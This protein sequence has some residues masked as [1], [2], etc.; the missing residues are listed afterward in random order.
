MKVAVVT[1]SAKGLGRDIAMVL[2]KDGY[3]VVLHYLH[4]ADDAKKALDEIKEVSP[5]SI[6]VK[7]N[8]TSDSDT[9]K[10][11]GEVEEKLGR[12]DLLVNNVGNFL[13]KEFAKTTN[14]EFRNMI[15]SNLYST[16][17]VSRAALSLMRKQ[18]SGQIINIGAVGCERL[19]I[20]E[21]ST[22]YFLGKTGVYV[23][24]KVMA[25]DEAKHGIRINMISPASMAADIFKASDFPS[26]RPATHADVIRA[27]MFLIS[28]ENS[29]INGANLEV[30]G[31]FVPGMKIDE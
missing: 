15:E 19:I 1:G 2:A 31:A 9:E 24:T 22:P 18:K 11:V 16:L 4:S 25:A 13:Y 28:P 26:G 30:S 21:M 6:M 5:D 29:Y 8:V 14:S 17:Y 10:M 7:A 20:R 23:L 12:I 3:T 27:L